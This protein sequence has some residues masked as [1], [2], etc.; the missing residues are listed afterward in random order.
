MQSRQR[1]SSSSSAARIICFLNTLVFK[2]CAVFEARHGDEPRKKR[3]GLMRVW[4]FLMNSDHHGK[5]VTRHV[6]P[7]TENGIALL[8]KNKTIIHNNISKVTTASPRLAASS[9][10]M[11]CFVYLRAMPWILRLGDSHWISIWTGE[12]R[13]QQKPRSTSTSIACG[14]KHHL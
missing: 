13:T 9:T 7:R 8:F 10:A 11:Q 1:Q 6:L 14:I 2:D 4:C 12:R 5:R 3:R